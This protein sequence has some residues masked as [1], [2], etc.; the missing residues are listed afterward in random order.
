MCV[1]LHLSACMVS[2]HILFL[3]YGT[4]VIVSKNK[5]GETCVV[6][7]H[8]WHRHVLQIDIFQAMVVRFLSA[9]VQVSA[10][11]SKCAFKC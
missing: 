11:L 3:A 5:I 1:C 6:G 2:F 8:R 10:R 7:D 9:G 4:D